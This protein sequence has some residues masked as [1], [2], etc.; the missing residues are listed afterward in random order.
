MPEVTPDSALNAYPKGDKTHLHL[1][2]YQR[3]MDILDAA[4]AH[5]ECSKAE[6]VEALLDDYDKGL[7]AGIKPEADPA[8]RRGKKGTAE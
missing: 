5:F 2:L 6:I 3:S 7:R 4:A 8:R 1:S